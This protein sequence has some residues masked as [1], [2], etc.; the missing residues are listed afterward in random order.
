[1]KLLKSS[2]IWSMKPSQEIRIWSL[3]K[4]Q[5]N[6]GES[7]LYENLAAF[8]DIVC[9]IAQWLIYVRKCTFRF[10]QRV[11]KLLFLFQIPEKN[12]KHVWHIETPKGL[13]VRQF[14]NEVCP[15]CLNNLLSS[16][17][18]KLLLFPMLF[19]WRFL[20]NSS[21]LILFC[22]SLNLQ[23]YAC[24]NLKLINNYILMT[25]IYITDHLTEG[26]G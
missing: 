1:M 9:V 11:P 17:I 22:C 21:W 14:F 4:D 20:K 7:N 24:H 15:I 8:Q 10:L 5:F 3:L 18:N 25:K 16:L 6:W 12:V 23:S 13:Q 19:W 26:C 2:Q